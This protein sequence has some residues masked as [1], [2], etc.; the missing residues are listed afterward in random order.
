M[1]YAPEAL[2]WVSTQRTEPLHQS[3]DHRSI[4]RTTMR[5][6][7]RAEPDHMRHH[8]VNLPT[9]PGSYSGSTFFRG[10]VLAFERSC[11]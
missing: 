7:Q 1:R 6:L 8:L 2:G 9:K 5:H 4:V 3:W 11:Y 10:Q